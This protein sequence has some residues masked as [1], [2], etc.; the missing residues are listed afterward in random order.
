LEESLLTKENISELYT[1]YLR[2]SGK[3]LFIEKSFGR[4]RLS[5]PEL[6]IIWMAFDKAR[7]YHTQKRWWD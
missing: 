5:K 2:D 6:E 7:E 4:F 3:D 1:E